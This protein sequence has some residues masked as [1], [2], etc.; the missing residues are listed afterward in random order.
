MSGLFALGYGTSAGYGYG[1]SVP[2]AGGGGVAFDTTGFVDWWE[3]GE[4]DGAARVG[5]FAGLSLT[6]NNNVTRQAAGGPA[7]QN[8]SHF[9]AASL[10]S[11]TRAS[12]AALQS[13]DIDFTVAVWVYLDSVGLRSFVSK[14]DVGLNREFMVGL[15]SLAAFLFRMGATDLT[16]GTMSTGQW[17][18][19]V[20]WHNATLNTM[21]LQINNGAAASQAEAVISAGSAVFAVGKRDNATPLHHD[22]RI[23]PLLY[24]KRLLT[25]NEKTWLYNGGVGRVYTDLA[26]YTGG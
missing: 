25:A 26:N 1:G 11:L 12:E 6:N 15:G 8:A 7:G 2:A 9:T 3:M 24:C 22:G 18:F 4:A 10:Q 13:G 16:T 19:I 5:S 20:A 14:D 21:N 17:Y 23:G